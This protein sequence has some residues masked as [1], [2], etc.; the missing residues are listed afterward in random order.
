MPCLLVSLLR[1]S[2][3]GDA[4]STRHLKA[5]SE[6]QLLEQRL[7]DA[8]ARRLSLTNTKQAAVQAQN[9]KWA[10]AVHTPP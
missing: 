8:D 9:T 1:D 2:L 5:D 6:R 3:Q 7:N 10:E 4:Y